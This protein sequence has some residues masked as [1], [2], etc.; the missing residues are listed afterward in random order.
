MT[1]NSDSLAEQDTTSLTPGMFQAPRQSDAQLWH[2]ANFTPTSSVT[3]E[4][5]CTEP[6]CISGS[7]SCYACRKADWYILPAYAV[8]AVVSAG[9][10]CLTSFHLG[11][12]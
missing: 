4:V 8:A 12:N 5:I 7:N 9:D 1:C 6:L 2:E 11:T 3:I 10:G